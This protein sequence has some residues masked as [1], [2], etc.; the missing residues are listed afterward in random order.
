MAS[1]IAVMA[2]VA[3]VA[4]PILLGYGLNIQTESYSEWEPDT[5]Y[6][7][8]SKYLKD[9][10]GSS[11]LR[12]TDADL[13][14]FNS[15]SFYIGDARIFPKFVEISNVKTSV[16]MNQTM[17][18]SPGTFT[19]AALA[20]PIVSL[21]ID[22]GYD[23]SNYYSYTFRFSDSTTST[24]DHIK[25]FY[26]E[27]NG[28]TATADVTFYG[29][30][31]SL[32]D[33]VS[34]TGYGYGSPPSYLAQWD[35]SPDLNYANVA[36]GYRLN[37]DYPVSTSSASPAGDSIIR[38]DEITE[39][40]VISLNLDSISSPSYYL[41]IKAGMDNTTL[42]ELKKA[43]VGGVVRWSYVI[44]TG[45]NTEHDLYYN[46]D[47]TNN[48]Y[49]LY[50]KGQKYG[51]FRYV[52]SWSDTFGIL[53]SIITYP[54]DY[55]V[56][57]EFLDI[58]VGNAL[59]PL[60][61]FGQTPVMRIDAAKVAAYSYRIFSDVTYTPSN[62]KINPYTVLDDLSETG[63]SIEFGGN[64]YNV[65]NG[66]ITIGTRTITLRKMVLDSVPVAGGYENRINGI[67]ISTTAN[68]SSIVFNGDWNISVKTTS[69]TSVQK[70]TT[71]WI[72]GSFVW[73]GVDTNF[74]LAGA[75]TCLMAFIGLGVYAKQTRAKVWPLLIV[76][77]GA[78]LMFLVMI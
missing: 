21:L 25:A 43:T 26:W 49:Q 70:E 31:A 13:Y 29:G 62:Y 5:V 65:T 73:D 16:K 38:G 61:V 69:Q 42:L 39:S 57:Y 63:T 47:L 37:T 53:P 20:N 64:T 66:N 48:T 11:K 17:L 56:R 32:S 78:G 51:E 58:D 60:R 10:T 52:G 8:T 4:I 30:G 9:I 28:T 1:K 36:K 3:V 74:K 71:H 40:V 2:L 14:Q 24:F 77:A 54:F 12:F 23:A 15:R 27:S 75:F 50:L 35:Y 55:N 67:V 7:D 34:V 19:P 59:P 6:V 44:P 72:P 22:G 46:P 18:T 76:C 41:R 33:V 45:D 68:P